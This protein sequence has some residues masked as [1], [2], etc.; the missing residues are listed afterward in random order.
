MRERK[1]GEGMKSVIDNLDAILTVSD[2]VTPEIVEN[3]NKASKIDWDNAGV[4]LEKY[5]AVGRNIH[6]VSKLT[7]SLDAIE[8]LAKVSDSLNCMSKSKATMILVANHIEDIKK[9]AEYSSTYGGVMAMVPM[10][11]EVL[12]MSTKI[13]AVLD[14]EENMER[15]N[16][17]LELVQDQLTNVAKLNAESIKAAECSA[18]MLN[19]IKIREKVMDEKLKRM[20][21]IEERF[22]DFNISVEFVSNRTRG[23]SNFN[24]D[25]SEL[26]IRIPS[27]EQGLP[28]DSIQG[29]RGTK[30]DIGIPGS[31]TMEGKQGKPGLNGENFKVD[32]YGEKRELARYGNRPVG[33]SFLSLDESP[34]MIY[35]RKS[36]ALDDWTQ[37]QQFGV[38]HGELS[39][40]ILT[41]LVIKEATIRSQNG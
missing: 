11:E 10:L 25:N 36:N 7:H 32:I 1:F 16:M 3:I 4:M 13:D 26:Q 19:E 14:L 6:A 20:E 17:K 39:I 28:G 24:R 27:G 2:V 22:E 37:G 15:V 18:N 9:V 21:R 40:E 31:A 41:D 30:G 38:S 35:F 29:E 8:E 34:T 33:T 23:S 12:A 5:D